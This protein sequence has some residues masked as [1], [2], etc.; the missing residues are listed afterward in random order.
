VCAALVVLYSAAA[1]AFGQQATRRYA[2]VTSPFLLLVSGLFAVTI[3][4]DTWSVAR[5]GLLR[6]RMALSRGRAG[7]EPAEERGRVDRG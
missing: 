2:A 6:A 1:T 3:A 5:A 7:A 4:E